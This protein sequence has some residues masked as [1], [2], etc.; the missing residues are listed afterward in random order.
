VWASQVA[1]YEADKI[2]RDLEATK[3]GILHKPEGSNDYLKAL[4]KEIGKLTLG[5]G[6]V[7]LLSG[8]PKQTG[9]IV[10]FGDKVDEYA[11]KIKEYVTNV[12]G[13]GKGKWQGKV[14][15][16]EKGSIDKVLSIRLD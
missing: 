9:S 3:L 4:E 11:T 10:I 14:P 15:V 13:G 16:W 2:K 5:Q 1:I 6:T 8:L 7:I 12:K